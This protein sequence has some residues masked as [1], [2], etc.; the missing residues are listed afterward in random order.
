MLLLLCA[1]VAL[2][3]V[4]QPARH[5]FTIPH[6]VVDPVVA[7]AGAAGGLAAVNL[8]GGSSK[9]QAIDDK[10]E[11]ET[12][13]N[14][15][16]FGRWNRIYSESEDVN[17]VQL[18]IRKG[19]A[20]TIDRVLDWAGRDLADKTWCDLGCGVGS[21]AIPVAE[22]GA[23]VSAS[24][25][26]AAMVAE[27]RRRAEDAGVRLADATTADMEAVAGA[28]DVVSCVDVMIHYPTDKM[29]DLVDHLAGLST[30][31]LF[32]S[33]APKTPQYQLLKYIGGL[34]PGPSKTTRA[35]LHSEADVVDALDK[36]GFD[37]QQQHL[38][39]TNFYF[40]LLLEAKK[41]PAAAAA[42]AAGA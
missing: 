21:L 36:A 27:T 40:S 26:S 30:D 25:I 3:F 10:E 14:G 17:T 37:V 42:A 32:V 24:D 22:R 8:L 29:K 1:N 23:A 35:Y 6:A 5:P 28:F 33:F 15:V 4:A 20:A 12:Y 41:R 39:A 18:D 7:V 2:G 9:K 11:V 19:H 31:R 34:F 13:F 16:G 38:T